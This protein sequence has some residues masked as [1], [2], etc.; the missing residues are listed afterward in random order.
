MEFID[1][2]DLPD[3]F[4]AGDMNSLRKGWDNKDF[5]K[6]NSYSTHQNLSGYISII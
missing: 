5:K 4:L 2:L 6:T 3:G 1:F